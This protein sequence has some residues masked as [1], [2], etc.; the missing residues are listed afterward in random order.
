MILVGW[1][2]CVTLPRQRHKTG[3]E[4]LCCQGGHQ[5]GEDTDAPHL[6]PPNT[7]TPPHNPHPSNP[8]SNP[9]DIDR[10]LPTQRA[11][12]RVSSDSGVPSLESC[13]KAKPSQ[14]KMRLTGFARGGG[15]YCVFQLKLH[16]LAKKWA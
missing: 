4:V 10:A 2:V 16:F 7:L 6:T 5:E 15:H 9:P 8:P 3:G 12:D 11:V 13:N 14:A 1:G